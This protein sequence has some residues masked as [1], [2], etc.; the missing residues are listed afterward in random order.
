MEPANEESKAEFKKKVTQKGTECAKLCLDE[1]QKQ[2]GVPK[3]TGSR[4]FWLEL[5]LFCLS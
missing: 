2:I 4:T 3:S 1:I 5:K